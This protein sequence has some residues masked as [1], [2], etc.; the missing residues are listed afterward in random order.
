MSIFDISDIL[1]IILQHTSPLALLNLGLTSSFH[2]NRYC[3]NKITFE[4]ILE[5]LINRAEYLTKKK[6]NLYYLLFNNIIFGPS[7]IQ[8]SSKLLDGHPVNSSKDSFKLSDDYPA[9]PSKGSSKFFDEY[10]LNA[11]RCS[12]NNFD[13]LPEVFA[14]TSSRDKAIVYI[15]LMNEAIYSSDSYW[16]EKICESLNKLDCR[17]GPRY[18]CYKVLK[19]CTYQTIKIVAKGKYFNLVAL[20][21]GTSNKNNYESEFFEKALKNKSLAI[22][23]I[24]KCVS[25]LILVDLTVCSLNILI[26]SIIK[27]VKENRFGS[28]VYSFIAAII[29]RGNTDILDQVFSFMDDLLKSMDS[30]VWRLNQILSNLKTQGG[31]L[32]LYRRYR[33]IISFSNFFTKMAEISGSHCIDILSQHE[34]KLTGDVARSINGF[35]D[36]AN[37]V[38]FLRNCLWENNTKAVTMSITQNIY[39][40]RKEFITFFLRFDDTQINFYDSFILNATRSAKLWFYVNILSKILSKG[41]LIHLHEQRKVHYFRLGLPIMKFMLK[42]GWSPIPKTISNK[43]SD[44]LFFYLDKRGTNFDGK[45]DE[46][47]GYIGGDP[48]NL[49]RLCIEEDYKITIDELSLLIALTIINGEESQS[50]YLLR[51]LVDLRPNLIQQSVFILAIISQ[52]H[53]HTHI[54]YTLDDLTVAIKLV[55]KYFPNIQLS[56]MINLVPSQQDVTYFHLS[57]NKDRLRLITRLV[58]NRC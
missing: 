41:G 7:F 25:R 52:L 26:S 16:I 37:Q 49:I 14:G 54:H 15:T 4:D 45:R 42:E 10:M 18:F 28:N 40:K 55:K 34:F 48:F 23:S 36:K 29:D 32:W 38:N 30:P 6:P 5:S 56:E 50:E 58:A 43:P 8:N 46:Y 44:L 33:N 24:D 39:N 13:K 11:S 1:N 12:S 3:Y 35:I 19:H 9:N 17:P 51:Q 53:Q 57:T 31:L 21:S 27:S 22:K 20:E 47:M 2:C